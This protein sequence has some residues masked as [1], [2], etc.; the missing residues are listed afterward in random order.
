MRWLMVSSLAPILF[1]V[2]MLKL[3]V[4][5][6]VKVASVLEVPLVYL[7][8]VF[9]YFLEIKMQYVLLVYLEHSLE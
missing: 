3:L 8:E 1:H 5:K 6:S 4:Y 2:G 7:L 9:W